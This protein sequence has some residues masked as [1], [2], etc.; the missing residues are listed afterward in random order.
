MSKTLNNTKYYLVLLAF[1]YVI[2]AVLPVR[3]ESES[4][5]D[6]FPWLSTFEVGDY[7]ETFRSNNEV[8][9]TG[10]KLAR[11][12]IGV[13]SLEEGQENAPVVLIGIHG[14]GIHG[15]EWVYP[16][17]ILDSDK[18][19]TFFYRWNS[20]YPQSES[21]EILFNAIDN[22]ADDRQAPLEKVVILAHSCGGVLAISSIEELRSDIQFEIHA[23]AAPLNGLGIFTFCEPSLP[24]TIP[25]NVI[26]KQWRTTR[27]KDSVFWWFGEDPQVVSIDPS[28]TVRLPPY[29]LGVRLGHV[30]SISWVA[31]QLSDDLIGESDKIEPL[32]N[33][34]T[35][36]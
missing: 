30:R 12:P 27:T 5:K 2:L 33:S 21:Q 35:H 6:S 15:Y 36:D 24:A 23:I 25:K 9:K 4:E 1:A 17:D 26:V 28:E 7:A 8:V 10:R 16:L 18:I 29:H 22:I 14:L 11:L 13:H 20:L 3:S 34:E 32:A 19:H 31:E